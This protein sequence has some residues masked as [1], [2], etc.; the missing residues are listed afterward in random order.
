MIRC[1]LPLL[2]FGCGS[3]DSGGADEVIVESDVASIR[4]E[5]SEIQLE[6]NSDDPAVV[7][8]KAFA[9]TDSGEEVE[10][11]MVA[12]TVSNLSAGSVDENG[13]FETSTLNGGITTVTANHV[14]IEGSAT[15]TV[16]YK[17]DVVEDGLS[18]VLAT[19][20]DVAAA[21]EGALP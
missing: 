19:A 4:V 15:V 12:W 1:L 20:F 7:E 3:S 17:Q 10:T 6:T 13:R 11:D 9:T 21:S 2:L 5:P 8:F 18:D 16:V 14:G